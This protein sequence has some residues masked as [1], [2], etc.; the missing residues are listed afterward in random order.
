MATKTTNAIAEAQTPVHQDTLADMLFSVVS[1]M[2]LG[3]GVM[4]LGMSFAYIQDLET[5][6][7][8]P[9]SVWLFICGVPSQDPTTL[10]MLIIFGILSLILA[11]VLIFVDKKM[12]HLKQRLLAAKE[13]QE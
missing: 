10:P 11:A 4:M 1:A 12:P 3:F 7:R 2:L 5:L 13:Q 9:E 6:R 8:V